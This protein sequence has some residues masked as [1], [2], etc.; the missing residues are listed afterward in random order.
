M[1]SGCAGFRPNPTPEYLKD[2]EA[3]DSLSALEFG[4]ALEDTTGVSQNLIRARQH[5][6]L[7]EQAIGDKDAD[8]AVKE[9]NLATDFLSMVD[10]HVDS[11]NY[12]ELLN[13]SARI[14]ESYRDALK[15]VG[16]I[17][18]EFV[19]EGVLAGNEEYY[20]SPMDV[21]DWT[22]IGI[23]T[24]LTAISDSESIGI[25]PPVPLVTNRQVTQ[26]VEFFQGRGHKV[27][28]RWMERAQIMLPRIQIILREE[29]LPDELAYLAM[30]ESGLNP[31]AYSW[32]H[33]SGIWQ[34]IGSTG[35]LYGLRNDWWYDERCDIEK[36]TR[37]A[38]RYL[39]KLYLEFDDWYLALAAYNCGELRV[40]Q[41]IR[42]HRTRDF[43]KLWRLPRQTE[44]YV[45][46][47]IATALIMNDPIKYG[48]PEVQIAEVQTPDKVWVYNSVNLDV[49]AK[50]AGTDTETMKQL[51]PHLLRWCTPP[52]M[53]SVAVF[54]PPGSSESFQR[55]FTRL[56]Q[57]RQSTWVR[58]RVR[59]GETLASIARRYGTTLAAILDVPENNMKSRQRLRVGQYLLIP[60]PQGGTELASKES[61]NTKSTSNAQG[62]L[63]HL[64]YKVR[65][66]D[67]LGK[68]SKKYG[69]SV[70]KL[71][72]WNQL[73][74]KQT[75]HVGQLLDIWVPNDQAD[76]SDQS[77]SLA[78]SD[79]TGDQKTHTVQ[80][81]E[82]LWVI[83]QRYGVSVSALQGANGMGRS[84]R[85]NPGQ[86]LVV[87]GRR[88]GG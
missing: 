28:L 62:D 53:D 54:I 22:D 40:E 56:P 69:V 79:S 63:V 85:L 16:K 14:L 49:L 10:N 47:Y 33:A 26:L 75:L 19:P 65:N 37:A 31:K 57:D 12:N 39:K 76:S 70:A 58:H 23:D 83:A 6:F 34:F 50:C 67:F 13:M 51:N 27:F 66:G 5:F 77:E 61:S 15:E 3:A 32:A 72:K 71:R 80:R 48:F 36:S 2:W 60:V 59:S 42:Q 81:G 73:S 38:A 86:V 45:P 78:S 52:T 82:S 11:A 20:D 41:V 29:G 7:A 64:T 9:L 74:A 4:E 25:F 88:S 68:I 43:W 30:I 21:S 35:R 87:P 18:D 84:T 46:S 17:P 8:R 1:I 44:D 55:E 24:T